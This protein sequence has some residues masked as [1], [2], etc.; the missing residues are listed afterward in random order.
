MRRVNGVPSPDWGLPANPGFERQKLKA[1]YFFAGNWRYHGQSGDDDPMTWYEFPQDPNYKLYTIFPREPEHLGWSESQA[2]R[3]FA[4]GKVL[5][6]G[7]NVVVM[8]HWGERGSDRWAGS[9][10][11]HTST[12]AHDQLFDAAV[13]KGLLIMPAIESS[14]G[15]L[16]CFYAGRQGFS[17]SYNFAADFPHSDH[18]GTLAPQ[19]IRQIEDL[20]ERYV[21]QPTNSKW[22][23]EWARMFDRKGN[24]R[25][26]INLLHVGSTKRELNDAGFA[27]AFDAVAEQVL[28]DTGQLV[29]FTLDVL[30][31]PQKGDRGLV[32]GDCGGWQRWFPIH[33]EARFDP[34]GRVTALW[35]DDKHLDLFAVGHDG[36]VRSIWYDQK[37]PI[38]IPT[39]RMVR[40]PPREAVRAR[41]A[42]YRAVEG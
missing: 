18:D 32:E 36:V 10:P 2:N 33:P 23:A 4:I 38:G 30:P 27:A 16:G 9:A 19:L 20:V 15:T 25:L 39:A 14:N 6:V 41:R 21:T 5:D 11:M 13:G 1:V 24:A 12:Y 29:G 7:T 35:R 34:N 26:A 22:P 8:S 37:E 3:D 42:D 17:E 40:H 28:A 31:Y